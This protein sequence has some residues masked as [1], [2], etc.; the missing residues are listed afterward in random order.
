MKIMWKESNNQLHK[1]FEFKNFIDA[2]AFMTKA[3]IVIEKHNHHPEWKNVY[4]KVEISLC[5]HD[6]GN[7]ITEKDHKLAEALDKLY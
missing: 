7:I 6:A 1:T 2:F 3:A 5:T 4:N